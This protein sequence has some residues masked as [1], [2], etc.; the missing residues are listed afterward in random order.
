[1]L[2]LVFIKT[3]QFRHPDTTCDAFS[4]MYIFSLILLL[5]ATSL[6]IRRRSAKIIFYSLCSLGYL[7]LIAYLS[8]HNYYY[9][10][11]QVSYR[12]SLPVLFRNIRTKTRHP[13]RL[14]MMILFFS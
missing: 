9:G 3:F 13:F 10:A 6:Y 14:S 7:L 12:K 1:M 11:I 2:V 4:V 5:E 8:F